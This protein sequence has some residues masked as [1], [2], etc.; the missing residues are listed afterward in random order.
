[1]AIQAYLFLSKDIHAF[2]EQY[3]FDGHADGYPEGNSK[4][5]FIDYCNEFGSPVTPHC[6]L[7]NQS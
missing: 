2:V 6:V 5:R 3:E 7:M 4:G 1:M